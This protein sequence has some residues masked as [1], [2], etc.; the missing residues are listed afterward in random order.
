M[1][2]RK[3]RNTVTEAE[4]KLIKLV[5]KIDDDSGYVAGIALAGRQYRMT[6]EIIKLIEDHPGLDSNALADFVF[7]GCSVII[8]DEDEV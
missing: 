4:K 7:S 6:E 3:K 2:D 5:R 1:V 8:I